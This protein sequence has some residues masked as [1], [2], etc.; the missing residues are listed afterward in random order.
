LSELKTEMLREIEMKETKTTKRVKLTE[1]E[2]KFRNRERNRL[3]YQ[4][5]SDK[6]RKEVIEKQIEWNRNNTEK[7]C[8]YVKKYQK[9]NKIKK[10]ARI[11]ASSVKTPKDKCNHHWS[12]NVVD[13]LDVLFLTRQEHHYCHRYL[14]YN[15]YN[16]Y[17]S[18]VGGILLDTK[19][20]HDHYI[21]IILDF[22]PYVRDMAGFLKMFGF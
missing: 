5:M 21:T 3:R 12:Y 18:T 20:K 17:F 7:C 15:E 13:M 8:E 4:T 22:A 1:N 11:M 9:N 19:E 6:E 2:R 14:V 16:K 10:I